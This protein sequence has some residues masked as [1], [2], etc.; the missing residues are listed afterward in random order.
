LKSGGNVVYREN[1][2]GVVVWFTGLPSSGKSTLAERVRDALLA[3]PAPV[4]LLD[5]DL[6]RTCLVP[7]LGYVARA[8]DAFYQ[9]LARLAAML[10]RQGMVVLVPATAYREEYRTQARQLAP[11]F[12]EVYLQASAEECAARDRA[13]LYLDAGAGRLRNVPGVDLEYEVPAA[14]DVV[15]VGGQDEQAATQVV[16]RALAA[17]G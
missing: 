12:L 16:V 2:A 5:G 10:A 17:L 8:R 6:V 3:A 13:G 15:A 7:P 4:C 1:M 14:P 11:A 9:T